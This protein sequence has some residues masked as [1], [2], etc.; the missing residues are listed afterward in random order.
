VDVAAG[1]QIGEEGT[2][3]RVARIQATPALSRRN[4]AISCG[5]FVGALLA[6][7]ALETKFKIPLTSVSSAPHYV[8][9]AWSFLHGRW[10]LD[11]S[12]QTT[13]IVVLHGKHYIVYPPFP[14]V[15]LMPFVAIFGLST[16]DVLFTAVVSA[17]NLPLL[18]LLFEQV[19]AIGF[20]RRSWVENLVISIVCYFGS[21]NLWLSLG[22]RM[23]FT[24]HIVSMT[25]VLL[26]LLL[27]F[28]GHYG[29]SA[30]ALGCAFFS[31]GTLAL[32][33]PLLFYLAWEDVGREPTL[34]R[35]VLSLWRRKPD[36]TAVPWRRL[37][38]P[39]AITVLVVGLFM[40]R[41]LVVFGSPLETGYNIL[42]HQR[43]PQVTTGPF[44]IR[45][46]PSNIVANFF[47]FPQITFTGPFDRHPVFNMLNGGYCVSVFVT[48]PLFL[49]LFTRNRQ[50]SPLRAA[51]W[52]TLAL[53]V[54]LVLLFHAAGW[55]QFGA[56]YLYD[57]YAY[58]Y[59][60]L[61]LTDARVDW[62]FIALGLVGIGVNLLGANQFWTGH[63]F[64]L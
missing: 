27:A 7:F 24:A 18:Y 31:R 55:V 2:T 20:T 57:G 16:S 15:M 26:S 32:G 37:L 54:A 22:G 23:W 56:R 19:R 62:R 12:A 63:V 53:I 4:L 17:C 40:W 50:F 58:A 48:T 10:D 52:V 64:H 49:L 59:L 34:V 1:T 28:R 14:A 9:Q 13:D 45:Y 46:V 43:Y 21:I 6:L 39:A 3:G 42:I 36:W 47:S 33:F 41:N 51:L 29:W 8:Y 11:L 35:F 25:C 38:L 5:L 61:A 44:N 60:L 30:V